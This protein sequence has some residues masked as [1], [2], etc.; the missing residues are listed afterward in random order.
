[1]SE[2]IDPQKFFPSMAEQKDNSDFNSS[3]SG[4]GK[5]E[6]KFVRYDEFNNLG[7]GSHPGYHSMK[8]EDVPMFLVD[9]VNVGLERG[10][11]PKRFSQS[12]EGLSKAVLTSNF[13]RAN[14]FDD[15]TLK[16]LRALVKTTMSARTQKQRREAAD[17]I[18]EYIGPIQK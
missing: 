10:D 12:I 18:L 3:M 11:L 9:A 14:I 2:E 7:R 16:K 5:E 4:Q 17:D 15:G 8:I 1:M 13:E 6:I